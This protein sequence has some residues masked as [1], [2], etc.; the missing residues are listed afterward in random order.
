MSD[1]CKICG[2]PIQVQIFRNTGVCSELCRKK[3]DNDWLPTGMKRK[4]RK[5]RQ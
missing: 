2:K 1:D 5:V 3:R 4:K